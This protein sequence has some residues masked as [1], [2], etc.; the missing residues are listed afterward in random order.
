[1]GRFLLAVLRRDLT[2]AARRRGDWL[3]AQFFFVM[4]ASLFP[5]GVG[6][7]PEMLARIGPGVLWVA[8]TLAS[9]LSLSRLFADDHHD[10]S[11]EHMVLSPEPTVLLAV[12]DTQLFNNRTISN[13]LLTAY[14]HR[15]PVIGFSPAYVKAGALFALY[16]TPAQIGQQAGE[17]ARIGLVSGSLPPATAPRQFRISTN[18]YVARSLGITLEDANVL[19]ERLERAENPP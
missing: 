18:T 3:I 12:P 2:L 7:E 13:I 1:M 14:H 16:S 17:A 6:P 8:A 5:L 19:R 11:L 15:S 9:L 10:G 4:T